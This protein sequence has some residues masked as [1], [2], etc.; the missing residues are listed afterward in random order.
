[1]E[2][3]YGIPFTLLS[4]ILMLSVVVFVHE[5]GHF[6]VARWCGVRCDSFSIGFGPELAGYTDKKGTRWKFSLIPLGG[7]V[8]MFGEADI[9]NPGEKGSTNASSSS[10]MTEEEIAVS[11]SHKSLSQRAAIVFAGPA[12]NFLFGIFI[13]TVLFVMVGRPATEPVI[14]FVVPD[15]AA[16]QAGIQAGDRITAVDGAEID[17]FESLVKS[18]L[19]GNGQLMALSIDR[20]GSQ[21]SL[22]VRPK[23]SDGP[24]QFGNSKRRAFLGVQ[25]SGVVKI[26]SRNNPFKALVLAVKETYSQVETTFIALGQ[27]I[28]GQRGTEDLGGPIAIGKMAGEAAESGLLNFVLLMAIL[29]IN[30][31]IINLFPVPLLDGGHLL[32]YIYEA[33]AGRPLSESVQEWGMRV[34]LVMVLGLMLFVTWNDIMQII[35]DK[36]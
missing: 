17:R 35:K 16:E 5:F 8:K 23:L 7:Y 20:G 32:F 26:M 4:F 30:L 6:I 34:G 31:G 12:V 28:S 14:G 29:S 3:L 10:L 13:F 27:I 15:S 21:I 25:S 18:V 33:L 9:T 2:E 1:M 24:D 19:L 36:V 22:S 11:F